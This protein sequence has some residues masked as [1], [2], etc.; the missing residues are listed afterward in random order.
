MAIKKRS[1]D[2]QEQR[3][4]LAM[5][6]VFA[7]YAG[8]TY[9]FAPEPAPAPE[10]PVEVVPDTPTTAGGASTPVIEPVEVVPARDVPMTTAELAGT[11]SSHGGSLRQTTL[12]N[13]AAPY[14]VTPWWMWLY[15]KVTGEDV[16]EWSAYGEDPG[17]ENV[18]R[19]EG[20]LLG[21]GA[22]LDFAESEYSLQADGEGW[23][24]TSRTA[25]GLTVRKTWQPTEDPNVLKTSV[26][27]V[28]S[29]GVQYVGPL[30]VGSWD[31]FTG[32]DGMM[33]RYT[34]F[35]RPFAYVDGD[36][37]QLE[38]LEDIDED[39]PDHLEGETGWF[40]LGDRYFLAVLVP[41]QQ[42]WGTFR[43]AKGEAEGS[44]GA[45]VVKEAAALAPGASE[46]IDFD[47]YIGPRDLDTLD[48]LGHD[49]D[50]AV[51]FGFFGFFAKIL[52]FV[53]HLVQ[54]VVG[55]W[56]WSIILLT[57]MMKAAFWP[58]TKKSFESGQKMK[59]LQ[60]EIDALKKKYGDDAQAAGQAQ[61]KLFQEKGVNP[62]SGCFPMLLQMPVWIS[63]YSALLYSAD[64][65]HAEFLYLDDL[66]VMDPYAVLP[67]FVGMMMFFQQRLTPMSPNMDP[68]QQRMMRLMPFMFVVIYFIFP[69]G[70]A[71]Y[72]TVNT[73]LSI[74]QMWLVRR[75]YS[76]QD[77][78]AGPKAAVAAK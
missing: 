68:A 4:I 73:S 46:R 47:V 34:N 14:D 72:A 53:L 22:S 55:S 63:L 45:F 32:G 41:N 26:E 19:E 56:G 33:A 6:V 78:T 44:Y 35:G 27:F 15:D 58:L 2:G 20:M 54:S 52:L 3:T 51:D 36:Y 74:L 30:W 62:M 67:L 71:L 12:P 9:F 64:L 61:M 7:I 10:V 60:P 17:I 18:V 49:L 59:N 70:L 31:R 21:A 77:P 50:L 13:H 39:G 69:A 38:S 8:W 76:N 24:A 11:V 40:G 48:E 65:Y 57:L 66:S 25:S 28:N 42:N 23:V 1:G 29:S 43:F 37:E 16:G 5:F 75:K